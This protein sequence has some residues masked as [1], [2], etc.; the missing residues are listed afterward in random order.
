MDNRAKTKY[1]RLPGRNSVIVR[2]FLRCSLYSGDDHILAIYNKVFS[3]YYK[4]FYY[5]DIQAFITRKTK[6]RE[7]WTIVF[8]FLMA[9]TLPGALLPNDETLRLFFWILCVIFLFLL[10][11]NILR[12]PTCTC[13]IVTAVQVEKLPSLNRLRV[14]NKA[15]RTIR[16]S[17]EKVQG[18]LSPEEVA[19]SQST[20]T[21]KPTPSLSGLRQSQRGKR[22]I[23]HYN[24]TIHMIVFAL[25]LSDG[26]LTSISL[27]N[28]TLLIG[29]VSSALTVMYT[30]GIIIALVKQYRSDITRSVQGITWAS[31]GFVCVSFILS[32][33]LMI[34]AFIHKPQ[35]MMGQWD[36]YRAMFELSP[37]AS[38]FLM[39]VY[40]F[41]ALCALVLGALGLIGVKRHH[42]RS[43]IAP[44]A[45]Q[46]QGSVRQS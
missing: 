16:F 31:L 27:L 23:R 7:A 11:I 41:A 3:E 34:T 12:G 40:G 4:R 28:H 19:A 33:I 46:N 21:A 20:A 25:L 32:Y 24:G 39:T 35:V 17:I 22:D 1:K 5:S 15:I 30:I 38:P 10:V 29:I 45:D 8:A 14:A 2:L 9:C 43:K 36:M 26:I 42:A 18:K 37:Q 6:I 44:A 13:H